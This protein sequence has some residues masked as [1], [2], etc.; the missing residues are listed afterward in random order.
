MNVEE[1]KQHDTEMRDALKL[2][3]DMSA[4]AKNV[5]DR[6]RLAYVFQ[7]LSSCRKRIAFLESNHA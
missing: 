3:K 6:A 5:V 1:A 2:V 7:V 4:E